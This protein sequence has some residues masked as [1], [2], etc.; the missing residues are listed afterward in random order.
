[1]GRYTH[2]QI[3]VQMNGKKD[4]QVDGRMERQRMARWTDTHMRGLTRKAFL[5]IFC[6]S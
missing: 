4:G 6:R 2:G 5:D 3:D 1:M